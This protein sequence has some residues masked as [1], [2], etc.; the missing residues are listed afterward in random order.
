VA[1]PPL[2]RPTVLCTGL[3]FL[4]L[5][6]GAAMADEPPAL[7]LWMRSIRAIISTNICIGRGTGERQPVMQP[8]GSI[9]LLRK[10]PFYLDNALNLPAWRIRFFGRIPSMPARFSPTQAPRR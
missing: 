9:Y 8:D 3:V 6:T 7:R 10:G 5:K 2:S 4:G 1:E